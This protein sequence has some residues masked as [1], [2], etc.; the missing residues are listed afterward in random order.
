MK[1]MPNGNGFSG[2]ERRNTPVVVKLSKREWV[3]FITVTFGMVA[4]GITW[5]NTANSNDKGFALADTRIETKVDENCDKNIQQDMI[6]EVVKSDI[7]Y[8]KKKQDEF[9][10][11]Q[12]AQLK[13]LNRIDGKL[14]R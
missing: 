11:E 1:V 5:W 12:Q 9:S 8:I 3:Y 13:L 14:G 7:N 6:L 2:K 10:V 4:G